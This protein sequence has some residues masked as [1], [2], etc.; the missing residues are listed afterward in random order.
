MVSSNGTEATIQYFLSFVKM[1]SPE[2]TPQITMSDR[3]KAQMNVVKAVYPKTTLLLCW[4][5]VL[6]AMQMHFRM[7]E[8]PELWEHV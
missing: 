5:H 1:H 2:I 4:W 8:F 6:H 7:E 3:D